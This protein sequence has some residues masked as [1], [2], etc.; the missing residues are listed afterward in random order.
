MIDELIYQII[1]QQ[2]FHILQESITPETVPGKAGP[3][4]RPKPVARE[5][6][7]SASKIKYS[8]P[9]SHPLNG[10]LKLPADFRF[11]IGQFLRNQ[12]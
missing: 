4:P 10:I 2:I 11:S 3:K 9:V 1:S 8:E 5:R 7:A 12:L 6:R